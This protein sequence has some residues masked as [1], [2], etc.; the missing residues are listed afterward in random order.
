NL[1]STDNSSAVTAT[2]NTGSSSLQGITTATATG[3]VATFSNLSYNVAETITLS[4][5]AGSL[6]GATSS[7]VVVSA[8]SAIKLTL[9]TQPAASATA[10]V[11]FAPQPV[12]RIEDQFGNL[13]S[14]DNATVVIAARNAGSGPLQGTTNLVA[15]NGLVAFTNLCHNVATNIT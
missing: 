8:A 5:N 12:I 7:N 11:T 15:V 4:F 3:G 14:S 1:I 2:R 10:G 13:R 9:Q 6:A